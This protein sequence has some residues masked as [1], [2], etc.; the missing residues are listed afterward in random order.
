MAQV[1]QSSPPAQVDTAN[2]QDDSHKS[3][4]LRAKLKQKLFHHESQVRRRMKDVQPSHAD[5]KLRR[6]KPTKVLPKPRI[7]PTNQMGRPQTMATLA[8]KSLV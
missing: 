8:Q 6:T 2:D 3:G 1:H 4:G 5:L 7:Y